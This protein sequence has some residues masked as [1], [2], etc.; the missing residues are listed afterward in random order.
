MKRG[1][2]GG[3]DV[4]GEE[5]GRR[6][7]TSRA[8]LGIKLGLGLRFRRRYQ[9]ERFFYAAKWFKT[10]SRFPKRKRAEPEKERFDKGRERE[11]SQRV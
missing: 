9:L 3:N 11:G 10:M 2:E 6:T 8:P 1:E 5:F 4:V 7:L